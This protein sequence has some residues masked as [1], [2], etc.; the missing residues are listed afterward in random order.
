MNYFLEMRQFILLSILFHVIG[1]FLSVHLIK[2]R[3]VPPPISVTFIE[4]PK[5]NNINFPF[6]K[7]VETK[8]EEDSK[9]PDE[10]DLLSAS[11]S[12]GGE[13]LKNEMRTSRAVKK[14]EASESNKGGVAQKSKEHD[15]YAVKS[16]KER[17]RVETDIQSEGDREAVF[18][19]KSRIDE[20]VRDN[21]A[22]F[23]ETGDEAI[24]SLNT[25]KFKYASYF[26]KIKRDVEAAWYYPDEAISRGLGGTT[27]LR[28][29]LLPSGEME[30]LDIVRSSGESSLDSASI[31]AVKAAVPFDPFP[32]TITQKR[33]HIVVHFT[34]QPMFNPVGS[35]R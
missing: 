23:Y 7:I 13:E 29:T 1:A 5:I 32:A 15:E 27:L 11:E 17:D 26:L 4:E 33:L 16:A 3:E 9:S 34:Y 22:G 18:L 30:G 19:E 14:G 31:D 35:P 6:G 2:I 20:I 12:K 24:V 8:A 10:A 21:P 25:K 28:F